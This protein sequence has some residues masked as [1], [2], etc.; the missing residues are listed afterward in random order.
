VTVSS[1][2]RYKHFP[3]TPSL[4]QSHHS[5][6][7]LI[8]NGTSVGRRPMVQCRWRATDNGSAAPIGITFSQICRLLPSH[9]PC[10]ISNMKETRRF[11]RMTPVLLSFAV[12]DGEMEMMYVPGRRPDGELDPCTRLQ[13]QFF[14]RSSGHVQYHGGRAN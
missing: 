7:H 9:A 13:L 2:E 8:Q 1:L 14:D 3:L 4:I 6:P 12:E 5:F 10:P 11:S